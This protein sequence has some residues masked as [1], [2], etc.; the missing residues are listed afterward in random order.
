MTT[1]FRFEGLS[2]PVSDVAA[3]VAFYQALGFTVEQQHDVFALLR[4]GTGSIGL[5]RASLDSWSPALRKSV[6]IE[7]S[8]E[9]LDQLYADLTAQGITFSA[10]PRDRQWERAM[11]AADPD[12]YTVEW[13]QGLRGHNQPDAAATD[14]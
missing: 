10:P 2:L 12:G 11:S 5:L 4:L 13:S 8:T 3:S 9:D 7:L 14:E 6:H 1:P